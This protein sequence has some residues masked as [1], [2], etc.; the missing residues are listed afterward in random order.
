MN[1][2]N[3]IGATR[4]NRSYTTI[5]R[6][7]LV[8]LLLPALFLSCKRDGQT[9]ASYQEDAS[10]RNITRGDMKKFLIATMGTLDAKKLTVAIQ[11]EVLQNIAFVHVAALA[12]RKD[13]LDETDEF[14]RNQVMLDRRA[15]IAAFD[16]YLKLHAD[17]HIYRMLE[18]Q[19]LYL[20]KTPD[21]DRKAEAEDLLKKLNASDDGEVEKIMFASNENNRYKM[22]GGYLDP[23]CISCNPNPLSFLTDPIKDKEDRKFV[24][25]D[26]EQGIFLIRNLRVR[27]AKGKDLQKIFLES[28]RRAQLAIR[29]FHARSGEPEKKDEKKPGTMTDEE[30]KKQA[31]EQADAQIRRETRTMLGGVMEEVKAKN[32]VTLPETKNPAE[33]WKVAPPA[34]TLLF[35]IGDRE[36][37]YADLKKELGDSPTGSKTAAPLTPMEEYMLAMQVLLPS[38]LLMR[39]ALYEDVK[40][41]GEVEYVKQHYLEQLVA[42][43][44][45]TKATADIAISD[46][47]IQQ[48][49]ELRRFNEFK[50]KALGQVKEQIRTQLLPEKRQAAFQDIK[51]KLFDTYK[52]KIERDKLKEGEV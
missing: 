8:A 16:L 18:G 32:A 49:Y 14:K 21:Q 5:A 3:P 22:Q 37:R 38:E 10:T 12:G 27:E 36:Y 11:D 19:L 13:K 2:G 48:Y 43:V 1:P 34:D 52:V 23:H 15:M 45:V 35:K 50:G 40:K 44:Y 25:V 17:D 20:R 4:P 41:S 51:K 33:A 7:A 24:L 28:S 39:S 26:N 47:D 31:T 42:N 6:T 29:K 9:L 30:M 46:A